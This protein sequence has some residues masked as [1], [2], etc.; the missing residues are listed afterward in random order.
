MFLGLFLFSIMAMLLGSVLRFVLGTT[1]WKSVNQKPSF[2]TLEMETNLYLWQAE[3][4]V[5]F[6]T[7]SLGTDRLPHCRGDC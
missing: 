4:R 1:Q 6:A 2:P 7:A 5:G 3:S